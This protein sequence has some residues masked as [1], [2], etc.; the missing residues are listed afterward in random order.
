MIAKRI[1]IDCAHRVPHHGGKCK[2]PHGH[3]YTI[4]VGVDDKLVTV[5]GAPNE[6]MVIDFSDIKQCMMNV[7]DKPFDH[8]GV[9][10]NGES[11]SFKKGIRLIYEDAPKQPVW[12]DFIPTAENLSKYW[13]DKMFVALKKKGVSLYYVKVWETAT[14]TAMYGG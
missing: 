4:E 9:Y 6:G 5:P 12:V 7:I 1:D 3:R 8:S 14:S 10:W 2:T 13:Y 11:D